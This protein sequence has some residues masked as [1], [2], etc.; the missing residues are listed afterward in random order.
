MAMTVPILGGDVAPGTILVDVDGGG[1]YWQ[2]EI[3]PSAGTHRLIREDESKD[4]YLRRAKTFQKPTGA[5]DGC[6]S[7]N[8]PEAASNDGK[9]LARCTEVSRRVDNLLLIDIRGSKIS[10]QWSPV[11][12]RIQGFAWAPNSRSVAVLN[13]SSYI[14]MRPLE[15][16]E[17]L[18]GHPVSHCTVYLDIIEADTGNVTE[19]PVAGNVTNSWERILNWSE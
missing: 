9:F 10:Y 17:A 3:N 1:P 14:G 2:Y 15:M 19:Y 18:S 5:I 16:L 13:D 4:N 12:R 6:D 8:K 11:G 7:S